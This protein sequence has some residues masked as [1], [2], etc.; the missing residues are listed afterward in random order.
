MKSFIALLKVQYAG[1][2]TQTIQMGGAGKNNKKKQSTG[3][4]QQVLPHL[5]F[6]AIFLFIGVTY[7]FSFYEMF[8]FENVDLTLY[9]MCALALLYCI[10]F[11]MFTGT[12]FL[13]S[14]KDNDFLLSMPIS[15]F[16]I[17]LSKTMALYLESLVLVLAIL[18]PSVVLHVVK[19]GGIFFAL[20]MLLGML[21]TPLL[22]TIIAVVVGQIVTRVTAGMKYKKLVSIVFTFVLLGGIFA[23]S[24]KVTN[25]LNSLLLDGATL[26]AWVARTLPPLKWFIAGAVE[27]SILQLLLYCAFC[28]VPFLLGIY[29]FSFSYLKLITKSSSSHAKADYKM[30]SLTA[31]GPFAALLKK[32]FSRFFSTVAL[33]VNSGLGIVFLWG[34]CIYLLFNRS[35]VGMVV[36]MIPQ[37]TALAPALALACGMTM[38][39]TI[40]PAASSISLE[41]EGLWILKEAPLPAMTIFSTKILMNFVLCMAGTVQIAPVLYFLGLASLLDALIVA[42]F[43]ALASGAISVLSLCANLKYPKLDWQNETMVIKNSAAPAIMIFGSMGLTF[44]LG[45]AY[46]KFFMEMPFI[47]FGLML[48]AL[49]ALATLGAWQLLRTWGVRTFAKL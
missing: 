19:G 15:P 41:G 14:G 37:I 4:L 23:G 30:Q 1:L 24:F 36:A 25:A 39:S 2:M 40:V 21:F 49:F 32:E 44:A 33:V 13:F 29:F 46:Y 20:L 31:R 38:L 17:M 3:R 35:T 43:F 22:P 18:G 27:G 34:G 47:Y 45:F 48:C 10:I 12:N 42:L 28:T 26:R 7:A 5:M 8:G 16:L 6:P 11:T 9:T